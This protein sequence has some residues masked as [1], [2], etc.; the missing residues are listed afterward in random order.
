MAAYAEGLNILANADAGDRRPGRRTPRP[1]RSTTPT[2]TASTI[3]VAEVA[4]VWRR[5]SVVGSW[6]L[7]LT[8]AALHESPALEGFSGRVSDSGEGRWTSIAA[9]E[10]GVPAP[11]LTAALYARFASRDLDDFANKVLSAMRKQ[12][13]GHDGEAELTGHRRTAVEVLPDRRRP[14][15]R[16][17]ADRRARAPGRGRRPGPIHAGGERGA[18]ARGDVRRCSTRG[19]ALGLGVELY[20]VDE[21]VAPDGDPDRNLTSSMPVPARRALERLRPMP[22]TDADLEAA[23]A[24]YAEG[25]P[26]GSTSSISVSART[27]TPRP[28]FPATRCSRSR[29]RR[30]RDRPAT[31]RAG[32][33]D[34]DLSRARRGRGGSSG[35]SPARTSAT[36]CRGCG[37]ATARSRPEG[38][39]P[40]RRWSSAT[41]PPPA[42]L[43]PA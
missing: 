42:D 11:V 12:F 22:V 9:I 38:S 29:T 17:R 43:R 39:P 21:R 34:A 23:A 27:A 26:S 5:G 35:W 25:F 10:E 32:S 40:R 7:D 15:A 33:D 1:R 16:R 3:D 8:A 18:H 36:R 31:T 28:S 13:G 41:A 14:P 30:G 24:R 6:L 2:D 37:R 19:V 20:Q 4:E